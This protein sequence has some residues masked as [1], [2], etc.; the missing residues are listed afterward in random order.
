MARMLSMCKT[1]EVLDSRFPELHE[2]DP[3]MVG[4]TSW[5]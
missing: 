4:Y 1:S 2:I 5:N 3:G